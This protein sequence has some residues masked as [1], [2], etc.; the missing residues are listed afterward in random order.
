MGPLSAF[1]KENSPQNNTAESRFNGHRG[2]EKGS[3]NANSV[4]SQSRNWRQ[5]SV[6]EITT[7]LTRFNALLEKNK[8]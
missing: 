7:G 5:S 6:K 4:Q 1:I 2:E 8:N 3:K